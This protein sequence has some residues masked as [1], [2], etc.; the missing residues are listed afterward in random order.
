MCRVLAI[1]TVAWLERA[2][3]G[4]RLSAARHACGWVVVLGASFYARDDL[5]YDGSAASGYVW[6]LANLV[7]FC[8]NSVIDKLFMSHADQTAAGMAMIT[9]LL[10]VP[11][12]PNP[13]PSP[14]PKPYP[15]P[16]PSLNPT[17]A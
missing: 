5:V 13:N 14:N 4:T 8:S 1:P 12:N 7:A 16:D 10:S 17:P 2:A 11:Y 6:A 3:L 15:K 9:Q